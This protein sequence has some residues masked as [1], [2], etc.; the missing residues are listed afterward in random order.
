VT[1]F[2]S[3][4]SLRL[5]HA[6]VI[7]GL[8]QLEA[9]S[10]Q[11][12][13]TSPPYLSQR[14]DGYGVA[15]TTWEPVDFDPMPGLG[16]PLHIPTWTGVLGEE[17]DA[18]AFTAHLVAAFREVRRVLKDNGLVWLVLGDG[19][20]REGGSGPPGPKATAH[21]QR[22][23]G[24][25][26]KR[27][28]P[29]LKPKD[30]LL[31]PHRVALALQ[32]DGWYVRA[33]VCWS[34][35]N[36]LPGPWDDRPLRTHESVFLLAKAG[37][38]AYYAEAVREPA[39]G[40]HQR[41]L[42]PRRRGEQF[43]ALPPQTYSTATTRETPGPDS[44]D[45]KRSLRSVWSIGTVGYRGRQ[46]KHVA[47][48]PSKLARLCVLSSTRPGDVVLDP[49]NGAG[50]T[51]LVCLS[52]GREYVGVELSRESCAESVDRWARS[53]PLFVPLLRKI[54]GGGV[55]P[56]IRLVLWLWILMCGAG[57]F[58]DDVPVV[59]D[60]GLAA[61]ATLMAVCLWQVVIVPLAR[62]LRR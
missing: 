46:G 10:V 55:K 42:S 3:G 30:A 60:V 4:G 1:V 57:V 15:A 18:Y 62:R 54:P 16:R 6:D 12:C 31:I 8:R 5:Y 43:S 27:V 50:T 26:M 38:Y 37:R 32:A 47:T 53:F 21:H 52:E 23:P 56:M 44:A 35:P 25:R 34:K 59:G 36:G 49:F 45:G 40:R 9:G 39:V 14:V 22:N 41:R 11:A 2:Y 20:V 28:P 19:Y 7:A 51:G 33:D 24:S 48:F 29:G 61:A 17:D 58:A 13:V